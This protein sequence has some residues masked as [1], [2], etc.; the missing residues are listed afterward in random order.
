MDGDRLVLDDSILQDQQ[1]IRFQPPR[2]IQLKD[3]V[4]HHSRVAALIYQLRHYQP[5]PT[6]TD[7]AEA[8]LA[9]QAF[10]EPDSPDWKDAW[11]VTDRLVVE[12]ADEARTHGAELV[13][14]MANCGIEVDPQDTARARVM[15]RLGVTDLLYPE[16]GMA[17][18][19]AAH[20]FTVV[21]LAEAMRKYCQ[22]HHVYVHGFANTRLGTGHWNETG[23]GV[24]GDLAAAQLLE[25]RSGRDARDPQQGR[26]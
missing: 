12:I 26:R 1:R 24:A 25:R 4:V 5:A 15:E 20:G 10:R 22:E 3:F 6:P 14:L 13:V 17:A 8:G 16:R 11:A 2:W 23:H 18:L 19:G 7:G 9:M 21:R